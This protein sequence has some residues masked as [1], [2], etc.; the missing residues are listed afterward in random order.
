[1][2]FTPASFAGFLGSEP[3]VRH[4]N[5]G[6]TVTRLRVGVTS[7]YRDS[8]GEIRQR[9][10]LWIT[11]EAWG[12]FAERLGELSKGDPFVGI[13]EWRQSNWEDEQGKERSSRFVYL[14]G[15]GLNLAFGRSSAQDNTE[16]DEEET[17]SPGSST[18]DEQENPL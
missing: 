8:A 3:T 4:T 14:T 18:D 10:T 7:E 11:C 6:R 5:S 16:A 13:G 17:D 9:D 12:D 15:G 1:M 2:N